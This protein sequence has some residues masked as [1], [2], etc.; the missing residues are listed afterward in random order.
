MSTS[1][2][3]CAFKVIL[4]QTLSIMNTVSFKSSHNFISILA[5]LSL[6]VQSIRTGTVLLTHI[7]FNTLK[8][9]QYILSNNSLIKDITCL[10]P[11][12]TNVDVS[13]IREE[14]GM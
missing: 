11:K 9:R 6:T 5:L 14:L 2:I 13:Y 1:H 10:S 4:R 8:Y 12:A 3:Q 7:I